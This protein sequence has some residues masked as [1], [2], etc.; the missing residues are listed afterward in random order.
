[1]CG[2]NASVGGSAVLGSDAP[3]FGGSA[4]M[5]AE[6]QSARRTAKRQ[7]RRPVRHPDCPVPGHGPLANLP[8]WVRGVRCKM[9]GAS[10]SVDRLG[11]VAEDR[12]V[13]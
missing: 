10:L 12:R 13:H 7:A 2:G 1:M 8:S 3:V 6:L 11:A 4:D 5:C 9:L